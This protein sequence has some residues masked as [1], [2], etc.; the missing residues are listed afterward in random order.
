MRLG[1]VGR[2]RWRAV[3]ENGAEDGECRREEDRLV[4]MGCPECGR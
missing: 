3:V 1:R 4:V 2:A